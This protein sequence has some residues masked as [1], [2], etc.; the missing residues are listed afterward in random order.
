MTSNRT[1]TIRKSLGII[2]GLFLGL[3]AAEVAFDQT[4]VS[5]AYAASAAS[6][7]KAEGPH[8]MHSI[9][10]LKP[11]P[12]ASGWFGKVV[13]VSILLFLAAVALGP[14]AMSLKAPLPPER[15]EAHGHDA[16]GTAGHAAH[17]GH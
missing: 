8:V 10:A 3:I 12:S 16:H 17:G 6:D 9:D 15:D 1:R 5:T 7:A 11:G 2:V 13:R 14:V 4:P